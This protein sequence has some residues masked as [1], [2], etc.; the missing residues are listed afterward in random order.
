MALLT[1]AQKEG[2]DERRNYTRPLYVIH[3][4]AKSPKFETNTFIFEN[5]E[6]E[7]AVDMVAV[8]KKFKYVVMEVSSD[9]PGTVFRI[10]PNLHCPEWSKWGSDLYLYD[11]EETTEV[12]DI[13]SC[14][15]FENELKIFTTIKE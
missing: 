2:R 7:G 6:Y 14:K 10:T 12:V 8:D 5:K 13:D 1:K 11:V 15:D 9:K 3:T 4:A